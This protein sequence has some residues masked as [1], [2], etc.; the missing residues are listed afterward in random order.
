[1]IEVLQGILNSIL[2]VL[3]A[4]WWILLPLALIFVAWEFWIYYVYVNYLRSQK[5]VLLEAKIPQGIEKTPK[6]MEQVFAACY[7]MYSFGLRFTEKYW[8]GKIKEDFMS[9]EL[10]GHSSGIHFYIR[11]IEGH[12]NLIESAIYAQYPDAEISLATSDYMDMMPATLP[13]KVYDIWGTDYHLI[14]EDA[15][16]IRTHEY[17]EESVPEK[18][19]DPI[20]TVAE[21]MSRLKSDEAVW[22]QILIRPTGPEW[23]KKGEVIRDKLI[24]RKA[25][26]APA[27]FVD[28]IIT[29]AKNLFNAP[30]K[31]PEWPEAMKPEKET[32]M[33]ALTPGEKDV[34]E[35][36]ETKLSKIAF[37]SNVRFLYIDKRKSFTRGNIAAIMST[38]HQFTGQHIN[39]LRPNTNTITIGRGLF[40]KQVVFLKKR[41]LFEAYRRRYWPRKV[42]ILNIEELATLYHFPSIVVEAPLL[43]R[44]GTKKG[45]PPAEL[46]VE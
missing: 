34:V 23:K 19:L 22:I 3:S 43:R 29:F 5:W 7:G 9:F 40:K 30:V 28:G 18:R 1:M 39:G 44:L 20:A 36:V 15:Y 42:G 38:F 14:R 16:P 31:P 8:D 2:I 25:P 12:R 27:G 46:P 41:Q 37:E 33:L 35:A 13:N 4:T 21:A 26:P 24:G 10:V 11:C 17:F 32:R 6:A 45:E